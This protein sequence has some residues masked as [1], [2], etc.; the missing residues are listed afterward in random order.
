MLGTVSNAVSYSSNSVPVVNSVSPN[1]G[2]F[3][4]EAVI[5]ITGTGFVNG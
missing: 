3:T 5:T 1:T 2:R 4:E